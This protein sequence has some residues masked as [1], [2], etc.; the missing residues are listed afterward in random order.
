MSSTSCTD[1]FAGQILKELRANPEDSRVGEAVLNAIVDAMVQ[2]NIDLNTV[3]LRDV[4]NLLS[5][6]CGSGRY[7]DGLPLA[8]F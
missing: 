7:A 2:A 5:D 6:V 1:E 4:K 3:S 8:A